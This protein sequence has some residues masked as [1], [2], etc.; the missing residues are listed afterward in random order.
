MFMEFIKDFFITNF[1]LLIV[2]IGMVALCIYD[3]RVRKRTSSYVIAILFGAL[4]LAIFL[5]L[6]EYGRFIKSIPVATVF[7]FLGY[8]TRPFVLYLFILLG[9]GSFKKK[10]LFLLIPLGINL[11]IHSSSLFIGTSLGKLVFFFAEHPDGSIGWN[12]GSF[13]VYTSHVV[14]AGLLAVL[15]IKTLRRLKARH[16]SDSYAILACAIFVVIAVTV[17]TITEVNGLLNNS[18]GI[19][20]LFYYLFMFNE[21]NRK[22]AITGL[23]DRK[24]YYLDES[25]FG[26]DVTGV[27][28]I[29]V[30]GLKLLNDNQGHEEGDKAIATL[31][32]VIRNNITKNMYGYRVGGDEF[33]IL[34]VNTTEEV[35]TSTIDA[36]KKQLN[37]T[38]YSASF[39]HGMRQNK[40][41]SIDTMVKAAETE[42]YN[43][44]DF[45]YKSHNIDRRR[46]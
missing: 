38:G 42:M 18:I 41:D 20:C 10:N 35:I 17:E 19:S 12:G 27:I 36:M 30:N 13:L 8:V 7:A 25:R 43:D 28:H 4:L 14:G 9:E 16:S 33:I 15:L 39:G 11:I 44:K 31:G 2:I 5:E 3:F 1:P 32:S 21:A 23:F 26:K 37:E 40:N 6:E 34:C 45:Y 24:T 29:D 22:D 46:F